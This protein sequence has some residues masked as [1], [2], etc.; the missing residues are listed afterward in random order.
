MGLLSA[1]SPIACNL[2]IREYSAALT[3]CPDCGKGMHHRLHV[4]HW[5]HDCVACGA[6]FQSPP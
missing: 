3:A 4:D 1:N 5:D 2:P 6:K